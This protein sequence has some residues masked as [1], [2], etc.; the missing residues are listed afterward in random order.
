MIL[1]LKQIPRIVFDVVPLE[2]RDVF[3]LKRLAAV[4]LSLVLNIS[5]H[6]LDL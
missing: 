3:L 1:S 4:M 6:M 5:G 2:K